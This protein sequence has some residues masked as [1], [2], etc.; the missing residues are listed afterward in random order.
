[1]KKQLSA[2]II[3]GLLSS[4]AAIADEA[5][6]EKQAQAAIKYRQSLLQL[7]RSNMG[8]LGAMAKGNIPFDA[9]VMQ[10]NGER[11]EQL[12][13]MMPDYFELDTSGFSMSTDAKA[14]IWQNH[15]D[16]TAKINDLVSAAKHLQAVAS[17]G[18]EDN[19][20]SAIGGVG[21]TCKGCHDSY[22]VD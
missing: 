11:L 6:S 18:D 10:K 19:Y 13:M 2:F 12:G 5:T 3:A 14:N 20:R 9:D 21:K 22:K 4:S 16:F 15:D 1:M 7:V 17:A 8:A